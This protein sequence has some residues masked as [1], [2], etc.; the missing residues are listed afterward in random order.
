LKN[1]GDNKFWRYRF[2][3]KNLMKYSGYTFE[4]FQMF[5][6]PSQKDVLPSQKEHF[7]RENMKKLTIYFLK[8]RAG[9]QISPLTT[10]RAGPHIYPLRTGRAAEKPVRLQLWF[11]YIRTIEPP[12]GAELPCGDCPLLPCSGGTQNRMCGRSPTWLDRCRSPLTGSS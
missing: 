1:S 7:Y 5:V 12:P 9:P 6:L 11:K 8:K 10:G 4:N 2:F 3:N